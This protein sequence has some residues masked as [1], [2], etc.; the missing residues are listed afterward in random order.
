MIMSE[1]TFADED[2]INQ[3]ILF[4]AMED[5]LFIIDADS[6]I[7]KT[8]Q[9]VINKMGYSAEELSGM[10]LLVLHPPERREEATRVLSAMLAGEEQKS[11]IPLYTR[12]QEYIPVKTR[13]YPGMWQGRPVIFSFSKDMTEITQANARFSKAFAISP[14]L[15]AISKMD[16]GEFIDVNDTFLAKLG[17]TREEV[18]GRSSLGMGILTPEQRNEIVHEMQ[19]KG[20]VRDKEMTIAGKNGQRFHV[21]ATGDILEVNNQ[22]YLLSIMIDISERKLAE[23][24]FKENQARFSVAFEC[25]GDGVWDWDVSKNR[26]FYSREWK[27]MLGYEK[28]EIGDSLIEW[29]SRIHPDDLEQARNLM[30]QHFNGLTRMFQSDYRMLVKDGGFKWILARGKIVSYDGNGKPLRM[31][32]THTDITDLKALQLELARQK[33]FLKKLIDTIPDLIFYKDTNSVYLGCNETFAHRFIGMKEEEIIGKTD[34]DFVKDKDLARTFMMHDQKTMASGQTYMNEESV[35]FN[36]GTPIEL[37]T[38]KTPFYDETGKIMGL[39]G[40]SRDITKRKTTLEQLALKG[41]MLASISTAIDELL[42]NSDYNAAINKCLALLGDATGVDRVFLYENHN[43]G[44][45]KYGSQKLGWN[46]QLF[47]LAADGYERL[48]KI[49]YKSLP[50]T[51]HILSQN[52]PQALTV[53]DIQIDW[54]REAL[55]KVNIKSV[56]ILP[57]IVNEY[58][59]GFVSFSECKTEMVWTDEELTI[60]TSFVNSIS[61]AIS[62]SQMEKTLAEAKENA[63]SANYAKSMFLAN[64]SHEIRT[65]MNGLMGFLELLKNTDLSTEQQEYVREAQSA[66]EGLLRLINDIL[67]F[68]KIEAGKMK[69]EAIKF[70]PRSAVAE[71]VSLQSAKAREKGLELHVLIGPDVPEELIGDPGRLRQILNNLLS[72]AVKFTHHGKILVT[73]EAMQENRKQ[74]E[75]RFGVSD[76]GIGIAQDDL[77]K[78]FQPFTQADVSTTRRYGGTGLGLAITRDLVN[79]MDGEISVESQL[80]KG[81]K[82]TFTAKFQKIETSPKIRDKYAGIQ[83]SRL[84]DTRVEESAAVLHAPDTAKENLIQMLPR[85]LLVEDNE[86]NQ[87]VLIKMLNK[88]DMHC[89]V[90]SSGREAL[91]A[92]QNKEYDIIFMDCQMPEMDGYETTARIREME[93]QER[94]TIIVA[95]TANAMP[96]EKE[97]CLQAGMDDYIAKPID[98]TLLLDIINRYAPKKTAGKTMPAILEEGLQLFLADSG[99]NEEDVSEIYKELWAMLP[100]IIRQMKEAL[101]KRDFVLLRNLAHQFKGSSGSLRITDLYEALRDLELQAASGEFTSCAATLQII[102]NILGL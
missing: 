42:K 89:D 60:L 44:E 71:A 7:V 92:L 46:S 49:S 23:E 43:E 95:M 99:L 29:E 28:D 10:D 8:N 74:I 36:D 94:H 77:S 80:G 1:P 85:L 30:R 38:I 17:F 98:F 83:A 33:S 81:T 53:K 41:K 5:Y 48:Q 51:Y 16:S 64:M 50:H 65:P 82:F 25:S 12:M 102:S 61:E 87:K 45:D 20:V 91:A 68:S 56:L 79:L 13:T 6:R 47:P 26:V 32:G 35:V 37:E 55:Q 90:V 67:D 21:I 100:D 14:T 22:K 84:A 15:M 73:A 66:S 58:F 3:E 75:L 11:T 9:S 62:R 78:L 54:L 2:R 88:N 97:K 27:K 101:E 70:R 57:V 76:T 40:I 31:I 34:L 93:G 96:G 59:W 19:S 24:R 69:M 18:V 39:I 86:I 4:N 63:E 52:K 72:N